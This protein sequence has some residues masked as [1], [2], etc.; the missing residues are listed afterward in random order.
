MPLVF[1]VFASLI[2]TAGAASDSNHTFVKM[3]STWADTE[4]PSNDYMAGWCT[5][6]K[7]KNQSLH[8]D[9]YMDYAPLPGSPFGPKR[10]WN[11]T[12]TGLV[13][14][15]DGSYSL[16][17]GADEKFQAVSHFSRFLQ[18]NNFLMHVAEKKPM[19]DKIMF[20]PGD[21]WDCQP[22][23]HKVVGRKTPSCRVSL[24][25]QPEWEMDLFEFNVCN[26][27][28]EKIH[29]SCSTSPGAEKYFATKKAA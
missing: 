11:T 1:V 24:F 2:F 26:S 23:Y 10:T 21:Q 29:E 14:G 8:W 12:W 20:I 27:G 6:S 28:W 25:M 22:H 18:E 19:S 16:Q 5:V 15:S 7:L 9:C 4:E 3:V 17:L 13:P